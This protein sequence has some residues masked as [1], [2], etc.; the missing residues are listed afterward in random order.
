MCVSLTQRSILRAPTSIVISVPTTK[1]LQINHLWPRICI[2]LV[3]L[4]TLLV[5]ISIL[6]PQFK[7]L[8]ARMWCANLWPPML[9]YAHK[10]LINC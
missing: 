1:F 6:W 5:Q 10:V 4:S 2:F 7:V 3:E 8:C 9:I